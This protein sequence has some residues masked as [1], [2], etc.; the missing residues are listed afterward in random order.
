M[1]PG[2]AGVGSGRRVFPGCAEGGI[3][4]R[5]VRSLA[6]LLVPCLLVALSTAR[7][8]GAVD[9]VREATAAGPE[10]SAQAGIAATVAAFQADLG[11]PNNGNAVGTQPAG[12]RQITWDGADNDS[13]PARLPADFF[14]AIAPRGA[15][16]RGLDAR[17]QFQQSA[18]SSN[19][20]STS[21]EFGNVNATYP[22]AFAAFSSP[23]LFASLTTN[24]IEAVFVVPGSGT[25]ATVAGFGAVFTDVDA[26][27]STTI[28]YFDANGSPLYSRAVLA[29]PGN[30][31]LS[32]LGVTFDRPEVAR[33][34]LTLGGAALGP[35]DVTQ[36]P[37]NADIVVVDDFIYG[38]PTVA[39]P[40]APIVDSP[41][42]GSTSS[43]E[44]LSVTGT[45]E[46]GSTVTLLDGATGVGTDTAAGDGRWRIAPQVLFPD[47]A[48]TFT[49]V[50]ANSAGSSAASNAVT[51]G[52]AVP[53]ESRVCSV[54][55]P[56]TF[57]PLGAPTIV[58]GRRQVTITMDD[59]GTDVAYVVEI[60]CRRGGRR[61]TTT[62]VLFASSVTIRRPRGRRC[63]YRYS[64]V[65]GGMRSEPSRV[66]R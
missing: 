1:L 19:A 49:A 22:T 55:P 8:H 18:D 24:V 35:N 14:N 29:T 16:F 6:V 13:A 31:S 51:V 15:V 45:A 41:G 17:A 4:L 28:E 12:R 64:I 2:S 42:D 27:G 65:A 37:G 48:R 25:P 62:E 10:A 20:T 40:P 44:Y 47:G 7:A 61:V 52:F 32:F 38:E 3:T 58:T 46:P 26:T 60:T 34:R 30:E 57:A 23:R 53:P 11:N 54:A 21:V 63:A 43:L 59:Y 39:A 33:V 50:A 56:I 66:G 5:M 36:T 9:I